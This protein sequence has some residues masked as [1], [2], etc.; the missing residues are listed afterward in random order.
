MNSCEIEIAVARHFGAEMNLIV[1]NIFFHYELDLIIV[2]QR[3]YAW[4]VE[5]KTSISDLKAEKKKSPLAHISDKIKRLYF[6]VPDNLTEKSMALIP[7]R[8]GLLR[9]V[10]INGRL[11]VCLEKAPQTN[12]NARKLTEKEMIKLGKLAAM[13][14]WNLKESLLKE[15]RKRESQ[16]K[17]GNDGH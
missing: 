8:A 17:R 9:V 7:E 3:H 14:I 2:N 1:P 5:I 11:V 13:R 4:E 16:E 6:A 12:K 15:K 10:N